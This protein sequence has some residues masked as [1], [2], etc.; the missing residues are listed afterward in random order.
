M[1]CGCSLLLNATKRDGELPGTFLCFS[2][3]APKGWNG[4]LIRARQ[5]GMYKEQYYQSFDT[6]YPFLVLFINRGMECKKMDPMTISHTRY[7][8]IVTDIINDV[9]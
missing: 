3:G 7:S 9:E 5:R 2:N 6:M 8:K 4:T 1:E